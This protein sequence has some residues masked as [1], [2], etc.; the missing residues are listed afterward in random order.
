MAS[1]SASATASGHTITLRGSA[2]IVTE[3]FGYSLNSILYQR[4]LYDPAKFVKVPKYGKQFWVTLA[5]SLPLPVSSF[6]MA[7]L[8]MPFGLCGRVRIR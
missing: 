1:A 7:R 5:L 8:L 2:Q 6:C 4:G 3:F